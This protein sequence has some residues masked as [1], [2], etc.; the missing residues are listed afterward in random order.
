MEKTCTTFIPQK[1][2][3]SSVGHKHLQKTIAYISQ[4]TIEKHYYTKK[5]RENMPNIDFIQKAT[6]KKKKAKSTKN[7]KKT[8][9]ICRFQRDFKLLLEFNDEAKKRMKSIQNLFRFKFL[10][11]IIINFF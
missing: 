6:I 5:S 10:K 4:Q 11:N 3:R 9:S 7:R 8:N 2:R 1:C